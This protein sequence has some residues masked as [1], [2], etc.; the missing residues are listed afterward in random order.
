MPSPSPEARARDRERNGGIGTYIKNGE[1]H[2]Y[3]HIGHPCSS[4]WKILTKETSAGNGSCEACMIW[5]RREDTQVGKNPYWS[6][7][8]REFWKQRGHLDR[9]Y[10]DMKT[11]KF[12]THGRGKFLESK[13]DSILNKTKYVDEL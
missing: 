11:R 9:S 4:C 5:L 2:Y 3:V 7:D 10:F 8:M 1:V 13:L 6:D 12:L